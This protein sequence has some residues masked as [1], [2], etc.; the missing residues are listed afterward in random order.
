MLNLNDAS[1][2]TLLFCISKCVIIQSAQKCTFVHY[3]LSSALSYVIA[4]NLKL[5]WKLLYSHTI[6][7]LEQQEEAQQLSTNHSALTLLLLLLLLS[8][9]LL[10]LMGTAHSPLHPQP[11]QG[12][13]INYI[14][15]EPF[16]PS[17]TPKSRYACMELNKNRVKTCNRGEPLASRAII[18]S[19]IMLVPWHD[20]YC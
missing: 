20:Q 7:Y 13:K 17:H 19:G 2:A 9:S 4:N 18:L 3:R 1:K 14:V 10:S 6:C 15:A 12:K 16:S 8:R 11:Q 5:G